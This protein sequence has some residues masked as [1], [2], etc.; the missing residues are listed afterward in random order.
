[1]DFHELVLVICID[2]TVILQL[3]ANNELRREMWEDF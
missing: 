2:L 3:L 1:L